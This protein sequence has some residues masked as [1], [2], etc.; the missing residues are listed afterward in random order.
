MRRYLAVPVVLIAIAAIAFGTASVSAASAPPQSL[1]VAMSA[2]GSK[3]Q[4]L[5]GYTARQ[6]IK[7]R[8]QAPQSSKGVTL[9]GT[10]PSGGNVR[11]PLVRDQ[12]GQYSGNLVLETPGIWS[13]AVASHIDTVETASES[14]AISVVEGTP[15]NLLAIVIG[16]ALASVVAGITLIVAALWRR[17]APSTT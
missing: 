4:R 13:L 6:P 9:I 10:D 3:I 16:L 11:V 8:V 2:K 1:A 7:V 15:R 12:D 5:D 17:P 14:F